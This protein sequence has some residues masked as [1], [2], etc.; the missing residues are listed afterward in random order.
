[1]KEVLIIGIAGGT[2]S[3]KTTVAEGICERLGP[4]HVA[5]LQQDSYY[6]D[7]SHIPIVE[8]EKINFDHPE[9][10]ET[11]LLIEHLT[12]LKS[13]KAI[14]KP[15]YD[16]RQHIRLDK[17]VIVEPRDVVILEGILILVDTSIRNLLD[18]KIFVETD[19]DIRFMRRLERDVKQRGRNMNSVIEQYEK[20]VKPMHLA[21]IK[22]SKEYA[23]IV[24]SGERENSAG[25]EAIVGYILNK[26]LR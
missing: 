8:R 20:T 10:I 13:R 18:I 3:G 15:V 17:R 24:F 4:N 6:K 23:D 9:A 22:P 16:F 25:A 11:E 7:R 5:L 14:E 26:I 2:G 12:L 19:D 1:M 21:Y